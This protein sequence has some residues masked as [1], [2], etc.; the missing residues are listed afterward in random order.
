MVILTNL[1]R[2]DRGSSYLLSSKIFLCILIKKRTFF[3][4]VFFLLLLLNDKFTD[5]QTVDI[6]YVSGKLRNLFKLKFQKF[7]LYNMAN[8][9]LTSQ[10][11]FTSSKLTIE[12]LEQRCEIC[13]KLTL[14][15]RKRRL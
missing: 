6:L 3:L 1:E 11:S 12:T 10:S 9:F 5:L 13:S 15:S 4:N 7:S 14:K 8:T 2:I